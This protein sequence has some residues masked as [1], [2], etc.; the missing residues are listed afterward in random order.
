MIT[1]WI[2]TRY[3]DVVAAP[4]EFSFRAKG[5]TDSRQAH[6]ISHRQVKL[7]RV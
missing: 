3:D 6:I 4:N 2:L 1:A 5:W 7:V